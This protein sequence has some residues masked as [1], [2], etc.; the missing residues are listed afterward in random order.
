MKISHKNFPPPQPLKIYVHVLTSHCDLLWD[1]HAEL[2]LL[3]FPA[4]DSVEEELPDLRLLGAGEVRH[5]ES[6]AIFLCDVTEVTAPRD[7]GDVLRLLLQFL[8]RKTAGVKH[9]SRLSCYVLTTL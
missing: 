4:D 9:I 7:E 5:G 1:V 3:L 2:D 8:K 6:V